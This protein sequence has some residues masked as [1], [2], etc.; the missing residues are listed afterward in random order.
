MAT[1]TD[2][3][4]P[5][6]QTQ[7][8]PLVMGKPLDQLNLEEVAEAIESGE[9]ELPKMVEAEPQD[10]MTLANLEKFI[11]GDMTWAQFQGITM[12]QAYSIAEY[13]YKLYNEGRFHDS[14]KAFEG[15]VICNPY[16]AY[17]HNMLGAVY[18]QLDMREEANEEYTLSIELDEEHL[19]ANVNRGELRLQDGAFELALED[20]KKALQLDPDGEHDSTQRARALAMATSQALEAMQKVIREMKSDNG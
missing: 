1:E 3:K 4:Q 10:L 19:N 14:R 9:L 6:A 11:M 16:D 13:G 2:D 7:S 20:L 8:Q 17:F 5:Q 12:D 18:Q 15:L